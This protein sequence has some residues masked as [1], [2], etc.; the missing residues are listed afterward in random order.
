MT[1][2]GEFGGVDDL[3]QRNNI[4]LKGAVDSMDG[5]TTVE[6]VPDSVQGLKQFSSARISMGKC[7]D[8]RLALGTSVPGPQKDA[9]VQ[10][11][12]E[13]A[14]RPREVQRD[15]TADEHAS[16]ADRPNRQ[17]QGLAAAERLRDGNLARQEDAVKESARIQAV[18]ESHMETLREVKQ[19]L[20]IATLETQAMSE[21]VERARNQMLEAAHYDFLTGLPNR[22][23]L[24][25]RM[26]Q[27]IALAK[28][29]RKKLAVLFIDLDRFKAI[30]DSLGHAM[31]DV[32]LQS[33]ALRLLSAVRSSDIVSRQGGDEFVALLNDVG[34]ETVVADLA[35]KMC[36]AV[37][38][39]YQLA[40][41]DLHIGV[42]IGISMYPDDGSD[43][44]T[45]IRHADVAM[46]H[47]KKNGGNDYS[48]FKQDMNVRAI[49]RQRLEADLFRA[50]RHQ[51]FELYYQAQVDLSC[52]QILGT[53][54]LVRWNHPTRGML[55]P[56]EFM[57]IAE[58]CGAIIPMGR[59]ILQQA[60]R[61]AKCW[62]DAG[63]TFSVMAVNVSS[64][65]FKTHDFL[66]Q[67]QLILYETQLEPQYMELELTES[68]LMQDADSTMS[69]LQKLK[70][71][72]VKIAIDDF[73]TGYSSL[74]YLQRFPVDT[75]KIDQSFVAAITT[76]DDDG[77]LIDAVIGLGRNLRHQV[78]A[79]GIETA[80]QL[81]FLRKR[82]CVVG[83]GYYLNR[84]MPADRFG[85][86]LRDGMAG[87]APT[88]F[89]QLN[90]LLL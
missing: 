50:L 75:L 68:V 17:A 79:E 74:S 26:D 71:M 22:G 76:N 62:L 67:L 3:E 86:F 57:T 66:Q 65:Q 55:L 33:V 24:R 7:D 38:A 53:E 83:Q 52:G 47:I 2:D 54:A 44:D 18:L 32:L 34:D 58:N 14:R 8:H 20:V 39:S 5:T 59:W 51:Q 43:P 27:S 45:L 28:R 48:F 81:D 82:D 9:P 56:A 6:D 80:Q 90:L 88:G 69:L 85:A 19:K 89:S 16:D 41:H 40:H 46:Y 35:S 61:Q 15:N 70:K 63:L 64:Q 36:Q 87:N 21:E 84:A 10:S 72:G 49:E 31:G 77:I 78:I 11:N 60:C 25:E 4:K 29:H 23:L 12:L 42:T 1:T 13:S 73:G 30:N 37:S